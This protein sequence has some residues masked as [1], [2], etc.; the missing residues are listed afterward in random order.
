MAASRF[1]QK[2]LFGNR[3]VFEKYRHGRATADAHF[4]FFR[5][6]RETGGAA[7]HDEARKLF[8]INLCED[9]I[10]IGEAAIRNPHLLAV[11]N[12]VL[13]IRRKHRAGAR[14]ERIRTGLRL[15]EAIAGEQLAGRDFR[16]IFLLLLLR[17]EVHDRNRSDTRVAS[18]RN[19]KGP[20]SGKFFCEDRRGYFVQA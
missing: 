12:P 16:E 11:Q 1:V 18:V 6:H 4:L 5:A 10:D 19:R 9:D 7:L 14:G 13:S 3:S 8:P 2:I 17:T 20:I 15:G